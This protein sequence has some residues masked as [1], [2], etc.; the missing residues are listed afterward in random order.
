[1]IDAGRCDQGR[2]PVSMASEF[3]FGTPR[4]FSWAHFALLPPWWCAQKMPGRAIKMTQM[5]VFLKKS[6]KTG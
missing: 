2:R 4:P 3:P 1:M 5:N 6:K